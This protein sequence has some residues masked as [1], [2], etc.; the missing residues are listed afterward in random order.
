MM[1]ILKFGNGHPV[2]LGSGECGGVGY[3]K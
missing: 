2:V 1:Y 3:K